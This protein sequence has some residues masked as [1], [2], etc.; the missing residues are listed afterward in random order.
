MGLRDLAAATIMFLLLALPAAQAGSETEHMVLPGESLSR[1]AADYRV[2]L[3]L[4]VRYNNL[5]ANRPIR[6]GQVLIIPP[7]GSV[8][9]PAPGSY[10]GMPGMNQGMMPS[11]SMGPSAMPPA[12]WSMQGTASQHGFSPAINGNT[13]NNSTLQAFGNQPYSYYSSGE[14]ISDVLSNF[15]SS[16]YIP[17]VISEAVS[18]QVNG[19]VGPM[20]PVDFLNHLANIYGFIWYHDGHTL[21][22]NASHEVTK[23]IINLQAMTVPQFRNTLNRMGVLDQRFYW[24]EQPNEGLIYISGPPRYVNMVAETALLLD[25]KEYDRQNSKLTVRIFKL[26]YAWA[27]DRSF[28]FRDQGITVPGVA[29]VLQNIINGGGIAAG[30]TLPA[31]GHNQQK[32]M[33]P[34]QTVGGNNKGPNASSNANPMK[35]GEAEGVMINADPRLNAIIVHDLES[36]MPMYEELIRS[37]DRRTLQVEINVSI[38]DV[39]TSNLRELGVSWSNARSPTTSLSPENSEFQFLQPDPTNEIF[40][41]VLNGSVRSLNARIEML[42][43]RNKAK[44]LSRPSVL[45]LD[46][47]EAVLDNS[48]TYYVP[49]TSTED[50]QLFPVTYGTVLRVTPRIVDER[51]SKRIHLSV[52]V[53]DGANTQDQN[54]GSVVNNS[55][56][57]TQ[58]VINESESLLIGGFFRESDSNTTNKVPF[59]GDLPV[60]GN[61][62]KSKKTENSQSVRLFLITPRIVNL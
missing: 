43:Q 37:L 46:N 38:V 18:G 36:R 56:I 13:P 58:A 26:K 25:N 60:I 22:V 39:N 15:A 30:S 57:S 17:V 23:R 33:Q 2:P 5:N 4:L 6:V 31:Q 8:Q 49:V 42:A 51:N 52:N 28:A 44:I 61:L 48:H 35:G 27:T 19:R 34:A 47:L 7:T 53:Q 14:P 10:G 32:K 12:D 21:Y 50:A 1:I 3:E 16:L 55:S 62:F 59:L 40:T 45:T 11:A 54:V 41:T 20:A 24:R 29:T 9:Q